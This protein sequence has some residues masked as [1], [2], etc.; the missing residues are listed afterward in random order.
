MADDEG[1]TVA[2]NSRNRRKGKST[3]APTVSV[4]QRLK[5]LEQEDN[6]FNSLTSMLFVLCHII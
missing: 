6:D 3:K 2:G 1:W 5:T 4:T